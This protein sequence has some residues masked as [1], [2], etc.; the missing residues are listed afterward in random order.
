MRWSRSAPRV[1]KT[2]PTL[3]RRL[4]ADDFTVVRARGGL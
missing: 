4:D 2:N 3:N 1:L